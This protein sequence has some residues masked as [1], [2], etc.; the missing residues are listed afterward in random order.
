MTIFTVEEISPGREAG[1]G[2]VLG[3]ECEE[4]DHRSNTVDLNEATG[5]MECEECGSTALVE[6]GFDLDAAAQRFID[7][8]VKIE[9]ARESG[10][11][12]AV[13]GVDEAIVEDIERQ[14]WAQAEKID[15]ALQGEEGDR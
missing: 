13:E 5:Q 11:L 8:A 15:D 14:L 12:G 4:C 9:Q 1:V 7:A 6:T 3:A 2:K 10:A